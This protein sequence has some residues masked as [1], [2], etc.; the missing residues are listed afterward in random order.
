MENRKSKQLLLIGLLASIVTFIGEMLGGFAPSSET[1]SIGLTDAILWLENT[2]G[3]ELAD[4]FSSEF[5][6]MVSSF[7]NLSVCQ[8]GLGA[9][10]GGLGILAQY[11]GYLGI[12][13]Y[14][15]NKESK[16][17]KLYYFANIGYT[18]VGS[19][20]HIL[21]SML[22]Y[23]YKVNAQS[24]NCWAVVGEF[25]LWFLAPMFVVFFIG[26]GILAVTLF[27]QIFKRHTTFPKWYCILNPVL[28]GKVVI[29]LLVG[30]L[31]ASALVNGISYSNMGISSIVLF[32]AMLIYI[33]RNKERI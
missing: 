3:S 24:P 27:I 10:I 7:E 11:L 18:I 26:Y 31:P 32:T 14:F 17:A 6:S 4:M 16:I 30:I 22:T 1:M 8:I 9:V 19:M 25:S 12:Y 21:F 29:R 23:V 2:F 13:Q 5:A 28:L 15:N 20:I 33:N